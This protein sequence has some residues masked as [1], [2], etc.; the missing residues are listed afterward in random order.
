VSNR[1]TDWR[2][3]KALAALILAMFIIR[4]VTRVF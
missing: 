1:S 3:I 4:I 2:Y